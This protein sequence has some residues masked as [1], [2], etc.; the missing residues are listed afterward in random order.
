MSF[1]PIARCTYICPIPTSSAK[2]G[3]V[4]LAVP[5][6][7]RARPRPRLSRPSWI[8]VIRAATERTFTTRNAVIV[9]LVLV[10][11]K[12]IGIIKTQLLGPRPF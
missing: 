7:P 4:S 12:E 2:E 9:G 5:L 6:S 10:M 3:P 1:A 8:H 11:P